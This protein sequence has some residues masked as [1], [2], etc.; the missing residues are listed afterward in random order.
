V[1]RLFLAFLIAVISPIVLIGVIA[2]MLLAW[3]VGD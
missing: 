2:L 1:K 3:L